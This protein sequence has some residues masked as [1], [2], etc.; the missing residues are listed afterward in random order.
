MPTLLNAAAASFDA[1]RGIAHDC[2]ILR[3]FRSSERVAIL[4][5]ALCVF[6]TIGFG[7]QMEAAEELVLPL[8]GQA[9]GADHEA[10][11]QVSSG[12]Q[13]LDEQPRHDGLSCTRVIG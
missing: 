8:L 4:L 7:A 6:P 3:R 5:L 9:A 10:A 2:R 1:A 12:D 13:L 11:L